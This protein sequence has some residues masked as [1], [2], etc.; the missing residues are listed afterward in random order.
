[1]R[2][3]ASKALPLIL[4]LIALAF[5]IKDPVRAGHTAADIW[6]WLGR[7]GSAIGAFIDA[8]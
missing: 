5:L 2:H 8:L 7:V 1:M 4:L 6:D 3:T